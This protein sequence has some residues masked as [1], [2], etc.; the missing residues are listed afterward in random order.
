MKGSDREVCDAI[1]HAIKLSRKRS[2]RKVAEQ[3]GVSYDVLYNVTAG[4]T[5]A[6]A[7]IVDQVRDALGLPA[8]WPRRSDRIA[9]I[10]ANVR[11]RDWQFRVGPMEDGCFLQVRFDDLDT[12]TGKPIST[13]GR[14]FYISPFA[15]DEEVVKTAWLAVEIACRHEAMERFTYKGVAIFHPHR[16]LEALMGD[17]TTTERQDPDTMPEALT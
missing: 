4:R 14:K 17:T 9:S 15:T 12:D 5:R 16:S 2:L 10:V 13:G 11:F 7:W 3:I 8:E 6:S 1:R